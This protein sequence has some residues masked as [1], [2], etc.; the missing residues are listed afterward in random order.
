MTKFVGNT[1]TL[2]K[3]ATAPSSPA[4]GD[5]YY[6]TVANTAYVY[7]GTSWVDLAASGGGS[8]DIT[9]VVAG[10]GLT[11]G[12]TSGSATLN[13]GAGTGIT[14]NADDVAI[15]TTVVAR[16]TDKLSAFAATTSAE[17]AGVVSDETGSGALVFATS[18]TLTTPSL[19]AATATS[20]NGT[21]IPSSA[22]LLTSA[23]FPTG[24]I[25][26]YIGYEAPTGWLFC[27]GATY[28]TSSYPDLALAITIAT[29]GEEPGATF[30]VPDL[31]DRFLGGYTSSAVGYTTSAGTFGPN[32]SVAVGA[33]QHTTNV[34]HSH[35]DTF[36]VSSHASHTHSVDPASTTSTTAS[37]S[38]GGSPFTYGT[39]STSGHTHTT[40]IAATTS[41]GPSA[42][43]SHTVTG[44]VTTLATTNVTSSS[45]GSVISPK[46]FLTSFII[47][48]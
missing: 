6:D 29:G 37:Y 47:K 30:S 39:G 25:F 38:A 8:G 12:A 24:V 33:H 4:A 10:S 42:T 26:P 15:D 44:S 3:L 36:A 11:G 45:V 46:S 23:A 31:R 1:I 14:V 2:P 16:K 48:T 21:T 5:A 18:P 9:D 35:A 40:D 34:G 13:V 7:N 22:T 20:I 19:G 43:L 17:L 32:N 27:N 28:S 41:G